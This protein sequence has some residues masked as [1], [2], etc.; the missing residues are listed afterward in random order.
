MCENWDEEIE[1]WKKPKVSTIAKGSLITTIISR[2][3]KE[4]RKKT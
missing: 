1:L 2:G 4:R 3:K